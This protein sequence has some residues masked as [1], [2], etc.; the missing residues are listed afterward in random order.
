MK[1]VNEAR[2]DEHFAEQISTAIWHEK[3]SDDNP[4]IS[5]ESRCHGYE[6]LALMQQKSFAEVIFL[7]FR[8]ELPTQDEHTLFN[9]LLI[10]LIHPGPRHNATRAAMNAAVSKTHSSHILPLAL[11]V[12]GGQWQGSEE[13]F[14][15]AKFLLKSQGQAP[16]DFTIDTPAELTTDNTK[17]ELQLAP[18]F[19]SLY[20]TRDTYTHQLADRLLA[21]PQAGKMMQWGQQLITAQAN[22]RIGWRISGL[23]AACLVDLGFSPYQAELIFQIASA[24]GIAAQAAEKTDQ[25]ITAMPFL[26]DKDYVI[27]T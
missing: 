14:L 3:P 18:G 6:H 5:R 8:A 16:E 7:L 25:P 15:A 27:K 22:E 10:A 26:K 21:L 23:T 17:P 4:F 9:E 13:V 2:R 19:G 24:P 20:G 12:L 1:N 11:Q